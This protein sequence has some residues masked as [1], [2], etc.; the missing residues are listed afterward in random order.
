MTNLIRRVTGSLLIAAAILGLLF[1]IFGIVGIW[2]LKD[3]V[4]SGAISGLDV[5]VDSLNSTSRGLD[6]IAQ[7]FSEL[8]DSIISVQDTLDTSITT[9]ESSK[10]L[11]T[12]LQILLD[13]DLPNTVTA[14][15]TSLDTAY[16]SAKIIDA[17]LRTLTIF[18]KDAYNPNIPLHEALAQ[19]STNL[20][21]FPETFS[22]M[23]TSIAD[24][25]NQVD[26]IQADIKTITAN[27]SKIQ[28]SLKDYEQQ[29]ANY[30]E[31]MKATKKQ[32]NTI[33]TRLPSMIS[34]GAWAI[35]IF[36]VWMLI[37]QLGLFTQGWELLKQC[38]PG[39]LTIAALDEPAVTE[40]SE[41]IQAD[42]QE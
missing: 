39:D 42:P 35:T 37:A 21:G 20:S 3:D 8:T 16:E 4:A 24:T 32:V 15:Q 34:A 1:S 19:I 41:V 31:S 14:V 12:S 22:E 40:N 25:A 13:D 38:A 28:T 30:Q 6:I 7:S 5:I 10:P 11:L 2:T 27:I 9:I 36:L 33:K 26:I 18:N 29:L 23:E 17:V